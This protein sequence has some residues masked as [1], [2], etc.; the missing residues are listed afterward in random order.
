MSDSNLTPNKRKAVDV[1]EPS[2]QEKVNKVPKKSQ[3]RAIPV[4][5]PQSD[6]DSVFGSPTTC[7]GAQ[8]SSSSE[9]QEHSDNTQDIDSTQRHRN[10]I[11]EMETPGDSD[12]VSQ[13][14]I[15]TCCAPDCSILRLTDSPTDGNP[16]GTTAS[17][18][19]T[20][21]ATVRQATAGPS[22]TYVTPSRRESV[23]RNDI[24]TAMDSAS[25]SE[26]VEDVHAASRAPNASGL[27]KREQREVLFKVLLCHLNDVEHF[28]VGTEDTEAEEQMDKLLLFL[29]TDDKEQLQARLGEDFSRLD[30]ALSTWVHIR[31]NLDN[32]RTRTAYF[33]EPGDDWQ[34]YLSRM[35][36][37]PCALASLEYVN[38]QDRVRK[39][40]DL[41]FV[42]STFDDDLMRVFD[43]LT[44]VKGCNGK[45]AFKGVR[46]YNAALLEWFKEDVA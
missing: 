10:G 14:D 35:S 18:R 23:I 28:S 26:P 29:Q 12:E 15:R 22:G 39:N 38:F 45:E 31:L 40:G 19:S 41:V 24:Q 33:G 8:T 37:A 2:S 16:P 13:T 6:V 25:V 5:E 3:P 7:L 9:T 30:K 43:V 42:T 34:A 46:Q 27:S 11:V 20:E 32:F 1:D 36:N 21:D 17:R 44:M 4:Q